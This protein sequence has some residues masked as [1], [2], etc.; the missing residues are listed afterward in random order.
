MVK[1]QKKCFSIDKRPQ[2]VIALQR[3]VLGVLDDRLS[4]RLFRVRLVVS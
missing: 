3:M 1:K 4:K 2:R